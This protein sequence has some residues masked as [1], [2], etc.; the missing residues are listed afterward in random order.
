LSACQSQMG[1]HQN[2]A[3]GTH[4][5]LSAIAKA[6]T[7]ENEMRKS[8]VRLQRTCEVLLFLAAIVS[9]GLP[10]K[11][12]ELADQP[13]SASESSGAETMVAKERNPIPAKDT[14]AA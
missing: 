13:N 2:T 7:T 12:Q 6:E 11:A 4:V 1:G 5:F 14:D 8:D 10:V 9:L 3:I